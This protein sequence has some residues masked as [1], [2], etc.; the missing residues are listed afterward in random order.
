VKRRAE[1][2]KQL[3]AHFE[4]ELRV[5]HVSGMVLWEPQLECQGCSA[6]HQSQLMRIDE[7]LVMTDAG[8]KQH[9]HVHTHA[10][11]RVHTHTHARVHTHTHARAH[12]HFSCC[13][14]THA[15]QA[16]CLS[17]R[18]CH[19]RNL[20]M[21]EG[22]RRESKLAGTLAPCVCAHACFM[23]PCS[24]ERSACQVAEMHNSLKSAIDSFSS[25]VQ[26]LHAVIRYAVMAN[27]CLSLSLSRKGGHA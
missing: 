4:G 20:D 11:A 1:S 5:L 9:I 23:L 25:R 12:T 26:D 8:L 13:L 19:S 7:E 15:R 17:R 10:R 21:R 18:R 24:Q 22:K 3:Q 16:A 2:D 14:S 27:R 6:A